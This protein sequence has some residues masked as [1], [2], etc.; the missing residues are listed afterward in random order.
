M[1]VVV[2]TL[3]G[4]PCHVEFLDMSDEGGV[5]SIVRMPLCRSNSL[6]LH[7]IPQPCLSEPLALQVPSRL[8]RHGEE[9]ATACAVSFRKTREP[10]RRE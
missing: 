2:P 6:R 7:S 10:R 1:F 3:S 8:Q 4:L 5:H 9:Y